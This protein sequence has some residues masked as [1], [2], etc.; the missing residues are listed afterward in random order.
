MLISLCEASIRYQYHI[1]SNRDPYFHTK[2][3]PNFHIQMAPLISNDLNSPVSLLWAHQ[4][5]KE[6]ATIAAQLEELR[7]LHSPASELKSLVKRA[8]I[9]R[10]R[11]RKEVSELNVAHQKTLKVVEVLKKDLQEKE[12]ADE[13]DMAARRENEESCRVEMSR[14]GEL[15]TRQEAL[16]ASTAEEVRKIHCQ[17]EEGS[18]TM[19]QKLLQRDDEVTQLR[20]LIQ[21][22]DRKSGDAVTVSK[23][24]LERAEL[25]GPLL[26][27]L[28]DRE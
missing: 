23:D 22:L 15:L 4:L 16:L 13:A 3:S 25:R 6:H 9:D 12:N 21:A 27:A 1:L 28:S 14:L 17:A 24:N 26:P 8:E 18:A 20:G 11:F 2:S 19:A 10:D 7:E 5:R